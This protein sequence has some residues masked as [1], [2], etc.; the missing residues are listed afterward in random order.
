MKIGVFILEDNPI[1]ARDLSEILQIENMEVLGI[2]YSAEEALQSIGNLHPDILVVDVKLKGDMT[3]IEF[4]TEVQK[5]S[6]IPVV[7]L[8]ANSDRTTISDAL[9]TAPAA[10][11]TKPFEQKDLTIAIELAFKNHLE[12]SFVNNTPHPLP[13]IFIKASDRFEKVPIN[14]IKYLEAEGSYCRIITTD[15]EYLLT[16]NLNQYSKLDTNFLRIHRSY[17]VNINNITGLDTTHI[18]FNDKALPIGRSY[19]DNVQ[20]LLKKFT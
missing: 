6:K 14:T 20:G 11:L 2:C 19:K 7:Y 3:G 1:T 10:F 16:G 4:V 5:T 9:A 12:K 18:F 8:T 17:I 15:K 13:F